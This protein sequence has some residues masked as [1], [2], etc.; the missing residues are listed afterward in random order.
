[1]LNSEHFFYI[2]NHRLVADVHELWGEEMRIQFK[3]ARWIA[4]CVGGF[5]ISVALGQSDQKLMDQDRAISAEQKLAASSVSSSRNLSTRQSMLAARQS[6]RAR[7]TYE[8]LGGIDNL[9][10]QSTASGVLLRFSYRVMD[11]NKAKAIHDKRATPY[12]VDLKTGAVLQIPQ[13]PKVGLLRQTTN[14]VNGTEYWMAFSNKGVVKPG[15]RVNILIG[16]I[17]FNGLVVQ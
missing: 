5:A 15:S 11:A 13:M 4:V 1:M 8:T 14:P 3:R 12:L 2:Q 10:V 17:H 16:N 6:G 7:L 9:R